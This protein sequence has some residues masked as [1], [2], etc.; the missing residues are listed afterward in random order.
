AVVLAD[1]AGDDGDL[2]GDG[3]HLGVPAGHVVAGVEVVGVEAGRELVGRVGGPVLQP[4]GQ[5]VGKAQSPG[6]DHVGCAGAPDRGDELLYVG[7]DCGLVLG[8]RVAAVGEAVDAEPAVLVERHPHRVHPVP[9]GDGGHGGVVGG[10]V[11][12]AEALDAGVLGAG[13]VDAVELEG[14]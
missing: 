9:G 8:R 5:D 7:R 3:R 1:L 4:H 14:G 12:G 2:G 6:H 10:P 11:E 13:A